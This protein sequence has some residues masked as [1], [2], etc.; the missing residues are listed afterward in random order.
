MDCF[1]KVS[2]ILN[3]KR[4]C[5]IC[6]AHEDNVCI[7]HRHRGTGGAEQDLFK[8]ANKVEKVFESIVYITCVI[9]Y[10]IIEEAGLK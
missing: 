2:K 5:N 3:S 4:R 8:N 7:S 10:P 9:K 1:K 6:S